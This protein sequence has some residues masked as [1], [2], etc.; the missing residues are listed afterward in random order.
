MVDTN[1]D[2]PPLAGHFQHPRHLRPRDAHSPGNL[3]LRQIFEIVP[4]C[5]V[6]ELE[7]I[8]ARID[9]ASRPFTHGKDGPAAKSQ[10]GCLYNWRRHARAQCVHTLPM[11]RRTHH[12]SLFASAVAMEVSRNAF[13]VAYAQSLHIRAPIR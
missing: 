9:M 11:N 6:R 10:Y 5:H 1:L 3:L 4:P 2:D 13:A 7:S 8:L 12:R